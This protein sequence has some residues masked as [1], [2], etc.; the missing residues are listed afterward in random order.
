MERK[1]SCRWGRQSYPWNFF[2]PSLM[3]NQTHTQREIIFKWTPRCQ[4]YWYTIINNVITLSM[5]TCSFEYSPFYMLRVIIF[6][7]FLK[8]D[9]WL[10]K[11]EACSVLHAHKSKKTHT[12]HN[13][14]YHFSLTLVHS[15]F[16]QSIHLHQQP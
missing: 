10:Q 7:I 3:K 2:K 4:N 11:Y 16:I 14:R 12:G 9:S 6:A 13:S 5:L 8:R 1:F 15:T